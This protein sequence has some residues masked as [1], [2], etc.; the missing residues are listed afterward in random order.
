MQCQDAHTEEPTDDPPT[1]PIPDTE[2]ETSE[3]DTDP[4]DLEEEVDTSPVELTFRGADL[5]GF[6]SARRLLDFIRL[7]SQQQSSPSSK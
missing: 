7:R 4:M 1:E 2:G 5:P 6:I 3:D